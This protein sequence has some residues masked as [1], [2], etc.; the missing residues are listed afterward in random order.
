M[1][2]PFELSRE[3]RIYLAIWRKAYHE[4]EKVDPVSITASSF[5]TALSFRQGLY[6]AIRPYRFGEKFDNE[7]QK[8][9]ELFVIGIIK[10]EDPAQ[11]HKIILKKRITLNE[12]ETELLNL[13]LDESDLLLPEEKLFNS[14]LVEKAEAPKPSNPFYTRD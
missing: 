6:K 4:R 10:Q 7:L 11:P 8:A 9:A 1:T 5:Q 3:A 12:L 14:E 13:G 2:K